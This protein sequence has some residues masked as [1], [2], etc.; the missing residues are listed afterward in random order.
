MEE[1]LIAPINN[2]ANETAVFP[3]GFFSMD[4]ASGDNGD[5]NDSISTMYSPIIATV[6]DVGY[7]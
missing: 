5:D 2:G 6:P 4:V 3:E 7:G 1:E